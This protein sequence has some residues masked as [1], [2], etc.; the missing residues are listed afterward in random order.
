MA[1][2][3]LHYEST[4][5]HFPGFVNPIPGYNYS[6]GTVG[7]HLA[8]N[9]C[10]VLLPNLERADL[11]AGDSGWPAA[12]VSGG[13]GVVGYRAGNFQPA[14]I[15]LLICP[16]NTN[17]SSPLVPAPL[18]YIV[19]SNI[20]NNRLLNGV[21]D[22]TVSQLVRPSRT[23]LLSEG[24][25]PPPPPTL[26]TSPLPTTTLTL[27]PPQPQMSPD[28]TRQWNWTDSQAFLADYVP[29]AQN[30]PTCYPPLNMTF[31]CTVRLPTLTS[32]F[33]NPPYHPG[34]YVAT[35]CDGHAEA[36][37]TDANCGTITTLVNGQ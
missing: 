37:S 18:T 14:K 20:C 16:N 31:T 34:V 1:T 23:L 2:G 5:G 25:A 6:T 22:V 21:V 7:A 10:E 29:T 33:V 36:L 12:M 13:T 3:I 35:F 15:P 27:V 8:L 9:W 32:I 4:A 30:V 24:P 19:N 11:W 26:P 17:A 28:L